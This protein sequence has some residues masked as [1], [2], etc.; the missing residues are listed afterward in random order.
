[1][2]EVERL[3][4]LQ[5][6]DDQL[7]L[8]ER[9]LQEWA[10]RRQALQQ[11]L[12]QAETAR[13]AGEKALHEQERRLHQSERALKELEARLKEVEDRLYSETT[14]SAREA[15]AFQAEIEQLRRQ[16]DGLEDEVLQGMLDLDEQCARLQRLVEEEGARTHEHEALARQA[17][18]EE[19]ALQA[20]MARLR[21]AR[22]GLAAEVAPAALN[23][24]EQVR[25]AHGGKAVARVRENTC[26]GCRLEVAL[27]TRK[28]AMGDG[29]VRCE[30]CGGILYLP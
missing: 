9:K 30:Y 6:L 22:A 23:L 4:R 27:L 28:A 15:A 2:R 8:H 13:R 26:A 29:L 19:A 24:Y 11:A 3:Y 25:R 7:A 20:Q 17:D 10:G 16:K 21:E 12:S 14:R 1:M 18:Q 5:E